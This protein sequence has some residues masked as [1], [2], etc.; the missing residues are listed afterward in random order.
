MQI[1]Q[2]QSLNIFLILFYYKK[3]FL[4]FFLFLVEKKHKRIVEFQK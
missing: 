2:V 1:I 3:L 4:L